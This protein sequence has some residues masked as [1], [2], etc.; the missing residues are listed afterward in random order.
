MGLLEAL[1]MVYVIPTF[2][3]A[4]AVASSPSGCISPW[5]PIGATMTGALCS[6][7]NNVV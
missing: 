1:L 5:T 3:A 4:A 2:R 6:L 7:P